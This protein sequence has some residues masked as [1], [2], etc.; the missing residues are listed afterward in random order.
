MSKEKPE[1]FVMMPVSDIDGYPAG[2]F[3]EVFA[4]LI[5]PA[6]EQ[7]GFKPNLV[8][9]N[10]RS[11]L[12]HLEILQGVV[13]APMAICDVT[14]RNPNVLYELGLRQAFNKKTVIIK[15]NNPK[16]QFIFDIS[17]IRHTRYQQE[18]RAATVREDILLLV[19]A[20]N[21]TQ[22]MSEEEAMTL[23]KL[24]SLSPASI[25][26]VDQGDVL[27]AVLDKVTRIEKSITQP[28]NSIPRYGLSRTLYGEPAWPGELWQQPD[29]LEEFTRKY[30]VIAQ[31]LLR[32]LNLI[33]EASSE[34]IDPKDMV[35]HKDYIEKQMT[36]LS[37][38][39]GKL[40]SIHGFSIDMQEN[41]V[42]INNL[43]SQY[44]SNN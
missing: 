41:W 3:G 32:R 24:L 21:E 29:P 14:G 28:A 40:I 6:C 23:L 38:L 37:Y 42:E 25:T 1:C 26:S 12:I 5:K 13:N 10:K 17:G 19:D 18:L 30:N 31:K 39:R 8:S 2:H 22:S 36:K 44:I 7:T 11:G 27:Q 34:A 20:I 15:D 4:E 9:E 16:E 33:A 43:I 35:V